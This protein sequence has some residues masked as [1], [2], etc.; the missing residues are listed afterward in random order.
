[1]R[2]STALEQMSLTTASTASPA[3]IDYLLNVVLLYENAATEQWARSVPQQASHLLGP[4]AVDCKGWNISDLRA[5]EVFKEAVLR[6]IEADVIVVSVQAA[7][8][9][10]RDLNAWINAWSA[11]RLQTTGALVALVGLPEAADAS[12]GRVHERLCV[13]ARE[14]G[15]DFIVEERILATGPHAPPASTTLPSVSAST[16]ILYPTFSPEPDTVEVRHWGINE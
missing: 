16:E 5:A 11:H 2:A 13:V 6:A 12:S 1:M 3:D 15:L 10:P 4:Q 9:L 7:D 14:A 8:E